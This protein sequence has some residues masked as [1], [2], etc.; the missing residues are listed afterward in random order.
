[1]SGSSYAKHSNLLLKIIDYSKK[2][3]LQ[4][5]LEV[6][7]EANWITMEKFF[8]LFALSPFHSM[9][10]ERE[11]VGEKGERKRRRGARVIG[12]EG[13]RGGRKREWRKR[14]RE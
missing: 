1:M 2:G 12:G 13:E 11:R 10:K 8:F 6:I 5:P 14:R 7:P 3:L 9:N 4:R